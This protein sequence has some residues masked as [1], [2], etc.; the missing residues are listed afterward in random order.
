MSDAPAFFPVL[1]NLQGKNCL[2]IGAGKVAA[3]KIAGLLLYG[4]QVTVVSPRA[5]QVIRDLA[6]AGA[7]VWRQ[8]SFSPL[9]VDGAF[10]TVAATNSAK[11]NGAVFRACAAR[12]VL[13]NAVDDPGRCNFIYPAVVRRGPLQIAISTTGRSPALAARLR[14]ELEVLFGP[15]WSEWVEHLGRLRRNLL[16]KKMSSAART[17][18]LKQIASPEAFHAF[19]QERA[20]K[21]LTLP[22]GKL[23]RK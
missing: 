8:R 14:R 4:A 2:V 16:G 23:R 9:D 15:E 22:A 17:R 12:G 11:I 20:N 7:L 5:V 21:Q 6:K 13:C 1:V 3:A 10:L 18:R 19:V